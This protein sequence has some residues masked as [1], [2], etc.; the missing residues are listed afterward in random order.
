MDRQISR[1]SSLRFKFALA[2][3]LFS[4]VLMVAV[5]LL[6]EQRL[7]ETLV[8]ESIEKGLGI[9]QGLAFNA[10]DPLLTGD[11]LYLFSAVK[12]V[13]RSP[14]VTYAL[15]LDRDKV[16]RADTR[17][18]RIGSTYQPGSDMKPV[19]SAEAFDVFRTL[20][21]NG[22]SCLQYLGRMVDRLPGGIF[23]TD[24]AI[25]RLRVILVYVVRRS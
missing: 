14:G 5:M 6:L 16:I 22:I 13:M 7:R 9:A 1:F 2:L 20:D 19:R 11:D 25:A 23:R 21:Q 24:V 3:A 10:E 17:L 15:I 18:E 4:S 8:Q 12:N